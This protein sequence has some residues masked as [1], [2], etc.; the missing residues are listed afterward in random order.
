M[1]GKAIYRWNVVDKHTGQVAG[2]YSTERGA[3]NAADSLAARFNSPGRY[4]ARKRQ[5]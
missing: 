3:R 5:H 1:K 4:E 2:A